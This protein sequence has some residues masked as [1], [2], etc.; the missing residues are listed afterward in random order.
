[1]VTLSNQRKNYDF[2]NT[3]GTITITGSLV[4]KEDN[5]IS[6]MWGN[7]L[8]NGKNIG[9]FNYSEPS[10][11]KVNKNVSNLDE[12]KIDTA[13]TLISTIVTDIKSQINS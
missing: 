13:N 4:V 1:M 6:D 7:I 5:L 3:S 2:E 12:D 8:D 10:V 9:Q 11:G